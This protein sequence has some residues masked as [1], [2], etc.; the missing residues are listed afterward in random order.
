MRFPMTDEIPV[1]PEVKPVS[2]DERTWGTIVHLSVLT[3][4]IFPVL[5]IIAP[6]FIWLIKRKDMPFVDDQGKEAINFQLTILIGFVICIPL[7]FIFIG[8]ILA[9]I[10]AILDLIFVILA[11]ISA[12][13]GEHYRYPFNWRIIK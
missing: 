7:A 1:T 11:G 3:G 4:V 13:K 12:N 10:L 8:I 5:T 9:P 6:L 2:N